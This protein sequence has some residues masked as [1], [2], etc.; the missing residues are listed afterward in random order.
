[1]TVI[2]GLTFAGGPIRNYMMHAAAS[3]AQKLRQSG[4]FG[5]LFGNGGYMTE[6][7]AVVL[8]SQPITDAQ[9]SNF[10][11]QDEADRR[12]GSMPAVDFDYEGSGVIETYTVP[13]D[14]DG[15]V[16]SGAIVGRGEN[17]ARFV[18]H[19]EQGNRELMSLLTSGAFE[20]IGSHGRVVKQAGRRVWLNV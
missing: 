10:D 12:R 5:L 6:A 8:A 19:A 2:G 15:A 11:V 18:C 1:M 20:P 14:R 4:N 13:H 7:H 3:M 16:M 17:G 9:H